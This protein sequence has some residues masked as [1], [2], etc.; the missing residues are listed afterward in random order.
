MAASSGKVT[1]I[2][3][4]SLFKDKVAI[5]TGGGTGIGKAIT[6]ELLYLGC[7]V[8]IASRKTEK[9]E[10][11]SKEMQSWLKSIGKEESQL[12]FAKCNIREEQ[13][14]KD[15]MST[16]LDN[17]GQIDFVVNNGGGQFLSPASNI[18]KKGWDAV[19]E[20]NLTGTFMVCREAYSHWME[21]NGGAI[22]NI[23]A[24]MWKGFPYMSHT[25][26]ARSAVD[27]LTKSL[28]MEWVASGVRVNAVAPGTVYS[29]TASANYGEKKVFEHTAKCSPYF[30]NGTV[31]EISSSVCFLLSPGARFITGASLR[32]D[33]AQSLY[34]TPMLVVP[35]HTKM[36]SYTWE[37][38]LKEQDDS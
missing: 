12:R 25:G 2:F 38:D 4:H 28:A 20:T 27:N 19:I 15:L 14:V 21:D 30:R 18:S 34:M 23:I 32:V 37:M 24:D 1:S 7:N 3:R 22:V 13:E 11:A 35:E 10:E 6:Q 17:F 31:E 8:L 5:V 9:L 29:K 36:P 26:A 16:T 33:G